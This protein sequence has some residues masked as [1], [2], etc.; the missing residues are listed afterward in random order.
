MHRVRIK[1]IYACRVGGREGAPE[2]RFLFFVSSGS[3]DEKGRGKN[4]RRK[5]RDIRRSWRIFIKR[6]G[7][8]EGE[9]GGGRR[10]KKS[11]IKKGRSARKNE[12]NIFST[13]GAH[14]RFLVDEIL[15]EENEY[16]ERNGA[17]RDCV[18]DHWLFDF[19]LR[20]FQLERNSSSRTSS[21]KGDRKR[22]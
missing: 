6:R 5:A 9:R 10:R 1:C 7:E 18:I 11:R 12:R 4:V 3:G 19:F 8:K 22:G 21:R 16:R 13:K 15:E 14:P 2:R 20:N 17:R